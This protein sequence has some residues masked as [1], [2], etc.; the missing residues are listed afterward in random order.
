MV[1]GKLESNA[2]VLGAIAAGA[3]MPFVGECAVSCIPVCYSCAFKPRAGSLLPLTPWRRNATPGRPV[4]TQSFI[5][6]AKASEPLPDWRDHSFG[7]L[8]DVGTPSKTKRILANAIRERCVHPAA[9]GGC[10]RTWKVF[11]P[12]A[13]RLAGADSS[14]GVGS[15]SSVA[16]FRSLLVAG[17]ATLVAARSAASH[18]FLDASGT[19]LREAYPPTLIRVKPSYITSFIAKVSLTRG[20]RPRC[21]LPLHVSAWFALRMRCKRHE[22]PA[23]ACAV[24]VF[25]CVRSPSRLQRWAGLLSSRPVGAPLQVAM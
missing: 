15:S 24:L 21:K 11:W 3:G 2:K 14:D 13:S 9:P 12:A 10:F 18:E 19:E 1:V 5:L 8:P 25:M 7:A 22:P 17:G 6:N 20:L 23:S 16:D 4:V